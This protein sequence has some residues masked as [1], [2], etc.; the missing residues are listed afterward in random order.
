VGVGLL[1]AAV[2]LSPCTAGAAKW[3][4]CPQPPPQLYRST[5][6]ATSSPFVHPGHE[7]QIVLNSAQAATGGFSVEPEG[8]TVEV[9]FVALFGETVALP[10]RHVAALSP[11]VL[12]FTFPD[13]AAEVGRVLAGPVEIQVKNGEA[14]V[15]HIDS[16]DLV[17]L[18]PTTDVTEILLGEDPHQVVYGALGADGDLWVPARFHGDPNSMP[19]CPG[20]FMLPMPVEIGA[21]TIPGLLTNGVNPLH[22]IRRATLYLGDFIVEGVNL[23]GEVLTGRVSLRHVGGT[24]GI[25]ICKLNDAL[26]LVLRVKGSR[27]WTRSG[28]SPMRGVVADAQPV[29]LVLRGANALPERARVPWPVEDSFGNRCEPSAPVSDSRPAK[30]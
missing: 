28:R 7:L 26:D 25:A 12:T 20:Q 11:S 23:Y 1:A 24:R 15:A 13:A 19:M 29:P 14:L 21:A 27:S 16:S 30:P 4:E 22:R 2:F 6:G 18:P 17:G 10:P 9:S 3:S 5:R 8:N